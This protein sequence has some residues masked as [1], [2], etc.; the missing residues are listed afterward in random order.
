MTHRVWVKLP[1]NPIQAIQKTPV[2]QGQEDRNLWYYP[3]ADNFD[4]LQLGPKNW[5]VVSFLGD[6]LDDQEP[7]PQEILDY[8]NWLNF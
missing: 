2:P 8:L 7:I 6:D 1:R 3:G 5:G 4:L